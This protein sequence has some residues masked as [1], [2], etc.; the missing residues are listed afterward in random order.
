LHPNNRQKKFVDYSG[1][2]N[3]AKISTPELC[4]GGRKSI[5][6][7]PQKSFQKIIK[8]FSRNGWICFLYEVKNVNNKKIDGCDHFI[9]LHE[10]RNFGINLYV[11]KN[12]YW[13]YIRNFEKN[14]EYHEQAGKNNKIGKFLSKIINP[15][16]Y[17][18]FY[19]QSE[20]LTN[21]KA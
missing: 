6:I 15:A 18:Q 8:I 1:L 21:E 20:K 10:N 5:F 13:A 7:R 11:H 14:F 3:L 12:C 4:E 19:P 2:V 16:D 9:L 17:P